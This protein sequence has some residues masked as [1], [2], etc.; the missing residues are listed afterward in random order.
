M[1]PHDDLGREEE[2]V[3]DNK[4]QVP[5]SQFSVQIWVCQLIL[6]L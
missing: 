2:E 6:I 1:I 4:L 3:E 5:S